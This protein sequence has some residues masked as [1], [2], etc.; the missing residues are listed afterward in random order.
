MVSN[1]NSIDKSIQMRK[2]LKGHI[3]G[4]KFKLLEIIGEGAKCTVWRALTRKNSSNETPKNELVA[5][6]IIDR[7][8]LATKEVDM[9]IEKELL[10]HRSLEPHPNIVSLKSVYHDSNR[11]YLIMELCSGGE[12]LN[13]IEL[14]R[15]FDSNVAHYF[16]VQLIN[17]VLHMHD[18]NI[19]H[20]DLK[21]ENLLLCENGSLKVADFGLATLTKIPNNYS[22]NLVE[23]FQKNSLVNR[24][25][26]TR[27][28]TLLYM[29][30]EILEGKGYR[31]ED[32]DVWSCG[33]ILYLMLFGEHP[34]SEATI[35]DEKFKSFY[36]TSDLRFPKHH[37]LVSDEL[38]CA[39][40]LIRRMLE[41][42]SKNRISVSEI[43]AHPWVQQS[44]PLL[45][46]KAL[47]FNYLHLFKDP[48]YDFETCSLT[49][50][51]SL[52]NAQHSKFIVPQKLQ[53][54]DD[55]R[56]RFFSQPIIDSCDN[57]TNFTQMSCGNF[58]SDNSN[59]F[60]FKAG[61]FFH[62]SLTRFLYAQP[63]ELALKDVATCLDKLLIPWHQTSSCTL[64]FSTVDQRRSPI[65]GETAVIPFGCDK[66]TLIQLR[67]SRG[68]ILEFKRLYLLIYQMMN[69]VFSEQQLP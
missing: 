18:L 62:A 66:K 67:K 2:K 65:C 68:D 29:A 20:R 58:K 11:V 46:N 55:P 1:E 21:P 52:T 4:G 17:A 43:M 63:P 60:S 64:Y 24:I 38:C 7:P 37:F 56:L 57:Q 49:Q 19:C 45:K 36:Y 50:P 26:K 28:G 48:F 30:P 53:N 3:V 33:I 15:G 12:L 51:Q 54:S 25:L 61:N 40:N 6:K 41:I 69:E 16:F 10:I 23:K 31:G 5:I 35:K 13:C 32:A 27:C 59:N 8:E 47:L 34:W 39:K 42:T 9:L 44:N 22:K 14:G